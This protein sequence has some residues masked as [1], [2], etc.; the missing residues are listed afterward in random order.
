M[1]IFSPIISYFTLPRKVTLIISFFISLSN[2]SFL[3]FQ[4]RSGLFRRYYFRT[5]DSYITEWPPIGKIAAHSAYDMSSWYKYLN[6][7]LFFPISV[8]GVGIFFLIVPFL[9]HYLLLPFL[10]ILKILLQRKLK[11]NDSSRCFSFFFQYIYHG[12][13]FYLSEQGSL[14]VCKSIYRLIS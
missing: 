5:L 6:A 7:N 9:D 12:L 4:E 11:F 8:C 1:L 3:S 10:I 14:N 2:L 13:L